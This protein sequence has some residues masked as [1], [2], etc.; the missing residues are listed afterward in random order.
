SGRAPAPRGAARRSASAVSGGAARRSTSRPDRSLRPQPSRTTAS[1][2]APENLLDHR[3]EPTD[4]AAAPASDRLFLARG[5]GLRPTVSSSLWDRD[6]RE[7]R[8]GRA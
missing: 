4:E 6:R 5:N 1:A 7:A 3:E 2:A 8:R